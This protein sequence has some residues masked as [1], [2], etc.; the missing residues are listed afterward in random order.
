MSSGK[1]ADPTETYVLEETA[2]TRISS[3]DELAELATGQDSGRMEQ[4]SSSGSRDA[5]ARER[6][7]DDTARRR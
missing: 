3:I 5:G 1:K 2:I 7:P 6:C 4:S